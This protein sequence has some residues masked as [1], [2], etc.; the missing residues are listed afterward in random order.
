MKYRIKLVLSGLLM[1]TAPAFANN[2]QVCFTPT[3]NCT[4]KMIKN[5]SQATDTIWL[6][7]HSFTSE[8][9]VRALKQAQKRG[10]S[11]KVLLDKGAL[12][13]EQSQVA[14][15]GNNSIPY[16]IDSKAGNAFGSVAII[17]KQSV[18]TWSAG[19]IND[20]KATFT[21]NMLIISDTPNITGQYIQ[22][23]E[24]R[25]MLSETEEAFCSHSTQ[26]KVHK[27][28]GATKKTAE[29]T[30]EGT[31]KLWKKHTGE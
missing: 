2:I 20:K 27:A 31:K 10:V 15:L 22:N 24:K 28:A 14:A 12:F 1:I 4:G 26:C 23:F 30:W 6:Q 7:M 8:P 21:D 9:L 5:I 13:Q 29:N 3:E 16:L 25:K 19:V 11:V 18:I 17:D